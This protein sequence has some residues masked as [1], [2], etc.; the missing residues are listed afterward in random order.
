MDKIYKFNFNYDRIAL[1]N[2]LKNTKLYDNNSYDDPYNPAWLKG[3]ALDNCKEAN[4]IKNKLKYVKDA[5][6]F[7]QPANTVI[8]P[9]TDNLCKCSLNILLNDAD[10][11]IIIEGEEFFYRCAL[12]NVNKYEHEVPASNK[13]RLLLRYTFS[14]PFEIIKPLLSNLS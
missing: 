13:D 9:H 5:V 1:L 2:D 10:A 4:R 11:P 12:I 7:V 8:N 3:L 14:E 6:F